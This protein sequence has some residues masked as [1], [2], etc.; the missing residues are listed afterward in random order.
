MLVQR[1]DVGRLDRAKR[2]GAGGARVPASISRTGV[3]VYTDQHGRTVREYRPPEVVFAP[4][5]LDTLA[6]IPVTVGHPP[7][8]VTP[9]NHREVSVGHVS[10]APPARRSDGP[11]EWVDTAVVVSDADALRRI[12]LP[13]TDPQALTEV[14]MGYLA[15][16]VPEQ[17]ITPIG[18][19][20]DARQKNIRFNHLALLPSGHARAGS[21]AKLRLDGNQEPTM[22]V[23]AD[24][25]STP[26]A[27]PK[28][29]VT[30]DGIDAERGSDTHISLLERARDKEKARADGLMAELTAAQTELGTAKATIAS[31]KP[32]D[33]NALVAD[34]LA[35]R[36]SLLPI[37]PKADGKPYDFSGKTRDAIRADVVGPAVMADAAKLPSDAERAGY[38]QAHVKLKLDAVGKAPPALHVPTVVTDSTEKPKKPVDKRA[39]AYNSSW[40]K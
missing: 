14:S 19:H 24:D 39:D 40:S 30:V 28:P 4:E 1:F 10:D 31:H 15:E 36:S 32:V 27:T 29:R 9:L 38:I 21:G 11:V 6:S 16:V 26:V 22:F 23:R 34:E 35:F 7:M 33:V 18:E 25:N 5:S 12:E 37:L 20:Y 17:G 3:Q 2:T 8:G 13:P